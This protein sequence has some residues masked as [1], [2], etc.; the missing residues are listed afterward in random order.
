MSAIEENIVQAVAFVHEQATAVATGSWR[1]ENK[2]LYLEAFRACAG[3][4]PDV[5]QGFQQ[6]TADVPVTDTGL[7]IVLAAR[8]K[9]VTEYRAE[10]LPPDSGSG[11]WL[12]NFPADRS[13]A[14]PQLDA[15][16]NLVRIL[17]VAVLGVDR[18]SNDYAGIIR[19]AYRRYCSLN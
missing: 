9:E 6:A 14:V 15:G 16:G 5:V 1:Y 8:S 4:N 13:V 12:R 19:E 7:G 17:S 10:D 2:R 18:P 11:Y 3:M